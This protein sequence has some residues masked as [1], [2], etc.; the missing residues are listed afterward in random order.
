MLQV[1]S[2]PGKSNNSKRPAPL[3]P[4]SPGAWGEQEAGREGREGNDAG[5]HRVMQAIL[6]ALLFSFTSMF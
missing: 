2:L 3:P 5:S 4:A 6:G 1:R